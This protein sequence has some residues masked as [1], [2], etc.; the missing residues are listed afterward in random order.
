MSGS[1]NES[2]EL[3]EESVAGQK[4]KKLDI[5]RHPGDQRTTL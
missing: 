3:V 1:V 2:I 5:M 4:V